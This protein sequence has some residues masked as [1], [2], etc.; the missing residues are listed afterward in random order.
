VLS[1]P[2]LS[3]A[4]PHG[5]EAGCASVT[6]GDRGHLTASLRPAG[7]FSRQPPLTSWFELPNSAFASLFAKSQSNQM[8]PYN[9]E[10]APL[11][12]QNKSLETHSEY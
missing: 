6:C 5:G 7:S 8:M 2:V 1:L 10:M 3:F 9:D 4:A 11:C 12:D